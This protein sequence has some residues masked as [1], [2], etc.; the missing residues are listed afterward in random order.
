VAEFRERP[1]QVRARAL[2]HVGEV[3]RVAEAVRAL[4]EAGGPGALKRHVEAAMRRLGELLNESH[5]SLREL[6][7]VSTPEVESLVEI[8]RADPEVYGARLMGGGF[9]GNV[10]ALTTEDHVET[11][12]RRVQREYYAPRGRDSRGEGAVMVSTPGAGLSELSIESVWREAVEQ[13]NALGG[14]AQAYRGRMAAMLD[15]LPLSAPGGEVWPLVVAA[16]KGT[17][18]RASGLDVPKPVAP[19]A[20]V[21]SVVRVIQN[22]RAA[23]GRG[24]PPVVIVSPETEPEVRRVLEGEAVEFVL[25]EEAL[26]TGDAVLRA[27]GV[28]RGFHGRALVVWSTQPVIRPETIR[29]TLNLAALF[30]EYRMVMPTALAEGPYAPL[31]RDERGRVRAARETRFESAPRAEF[32]ETNIGLFVLK[33]DAMFAALGDLR[34]S[35]WREAERRY[36]R[37]GGELGFPNE[38]INYF[39][40][41]DGGALA[42]PFA[43]GRE[44]QGI[45]VFDDLAR[46]EQFISELEREQI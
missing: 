2:H 39:S 37:P 11:L 9:G 40:G 6:Y 27:E 28:L 17:R 3:R 25:Q 43:D 44:A 4:A 23:L 29:R 5:A 18:A 41:R 24:R 34:R 20:R 38:L 19:V 8:I 22:L 12:T 36:E 1:L 7:G 10:L 31:L 42:C 21:P 13:F 32:G 33:C 35:L 46:C 16:G 14:G 26:G 45:K 30:D 15:A